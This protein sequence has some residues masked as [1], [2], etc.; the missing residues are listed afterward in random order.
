[1][2]RVAKGQLISRMNVSRY[3]RPLELAIVTG[4]T[5]VVFIQVLAVLVSWLLIGY[6]ILML[7]R[8]APLH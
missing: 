7:S 5:N 2:L 4:G 6:D 3:N 1:M 8:L